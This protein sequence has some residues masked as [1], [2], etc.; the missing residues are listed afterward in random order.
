MK[1][2]R[3]CMKAGLTGRHELALRGDGGKA[4]HSES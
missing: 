2:F 1:G 4:V 3:V